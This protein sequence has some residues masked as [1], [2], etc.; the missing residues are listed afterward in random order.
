MK[1]I[2]IYEFQLK[3][4]EEAL[5]I[6]SNIHNSSQGLTCHDRCVMNALQYTKNALAGN[7]DIIV[8]HGKNKI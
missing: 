3:D 8:Q 6:T 1:E 7:K 5:R 2:V 4:I